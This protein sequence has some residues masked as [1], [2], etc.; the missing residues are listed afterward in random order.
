MFLNQLG[1]KE[2][3]LFL[4]LCAYAAMADGE[5]EFDE[6][7]SIA[8]YCH[9]MMMPNHLPDTSEPL[10]TVLDNIVKL[11]SPQEK[12]IVVLELLLMFK[13]EGNYKEV[14]K[15]FMDTVV[16]R[17]AVTAEKYEEISDLTDEYLHI[18]HRV[19]QA[20]EKM[21]TAVPST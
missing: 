6:M 16:N 1:E 9:E 20:I 15:K 19:C 8:V 2:K 3:E 17:L 13:K 10:E 12:N 5:F 21:P 4:S 7:E 18:C 14:E 11:A